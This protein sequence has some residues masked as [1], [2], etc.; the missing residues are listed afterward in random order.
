LETQRKL[1]EGAIAEEVCIAASRRA[2]AALRAG[3]STPAGIII[4]TCK[5]V[6]CVPVGV[7]PHDLNIYIYIY[8]FIS[9]E[10]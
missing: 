7:L 3:S 4:Y 10:A 8:I 6:V 9:F 1:V 5:H 2:A